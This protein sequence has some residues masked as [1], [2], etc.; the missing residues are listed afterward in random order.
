MTAKPYSWPVRLALAAEALV[1]LA[2]ARLILHRTRPDDILARNRATETVHPRSVT[3][4]TE[5]CEQIA[6]VIPRLVLRLPWRADCLVQAL[7]AQSMLRRRHVPSTIAVGTAKHPDGR[8]EAHA[9]LSCR[10]E[11]VLGG[12]IARFEPLLDSHTAPGETT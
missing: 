1:A 8:F 11:I 10:G 4:T 2:H 3:D 6:Y 9:W 5:A 7:A 12:D